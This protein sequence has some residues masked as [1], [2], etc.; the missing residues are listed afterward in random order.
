M[1]DLMLILIFVLW[2]FSVL[3]AIFRRGVLWVILASIIPIMLYFENIDLLLIIPM[4][5]VDLGLIINFMR[6]IGV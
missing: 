4:I 5:L 3:L 6:E 1:T 2:M